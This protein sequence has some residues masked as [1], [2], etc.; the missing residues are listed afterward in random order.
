MWVG[1]SCKSGGRRCVDALVIDRRW[2]WA[3]ALNR[4]SPAAE[5]HVNVALAE[6]E[7]GEGS[8]EQAAG[9]QFGRIR[10]QLS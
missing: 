9:G 2:A 1:G 10:M 6:A 7:R 5:V 8:D 4:S 3:A